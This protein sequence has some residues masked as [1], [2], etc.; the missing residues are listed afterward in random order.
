MSNYQGGQGVGWG[1]EE[2]WTI[3]NGLPAL[4]HTSLMCRTNNP[5][6][7]RLTETLSMSLKVIT[8]L[9]WAALGSARMMWLLVRRKSRGEA[10]HRDKAIR[11]RVILEGPTVTQTHLGEGVVGCK[12]PPHLSIRAFR[13]PWTGQKLPLPQDWTL[14]INGARIKN[15][16]LEQGVNRVL[17]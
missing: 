12:R 16:P 15:P 9:G 3:P 5:S 1:T 13:E 14:F 17:R 8:V 6:E 2:S 11:V 4:C 7:K 10:W